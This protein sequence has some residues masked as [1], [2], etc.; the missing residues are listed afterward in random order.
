MKTCNK[1]GSLKD[2]SEFEKGRGTCK[3]CR[4]DA[5]NSNYENRKE[6][7]LNYQKEKMKDSEFVEKRKA[8]RAKNSDAENARNREYYAKN[9]EEINR[10]KR[11]KRS[12]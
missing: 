8:N 3:R 10:K 2:E 6:Y 12:N 5:K 4:Q 7:L 11:E 1:C 9:K